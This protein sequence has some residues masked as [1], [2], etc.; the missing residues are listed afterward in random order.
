MTRLSAKNDIKA[1][2]KGSRVEEKRKIFIKNFINSKIREL[3][4]E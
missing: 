3:I 4:G 2:D 1:G